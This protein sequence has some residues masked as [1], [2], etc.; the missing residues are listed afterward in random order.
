ML[1]LF[2]KRCLVLLAAGCMTVLAPS[3]GRAQKSEEVQ[4]GTADK[5]EPG[6][7]YSA[8]RAKAACVIL[9]H[10]YGGNR[11]Q[12]GWDQLATELQK[13]YA[14]L[15]FDF[16][17]HGDSTNVNPDFWHC[18]NNQLI[19]GSGRQPAKISYKDFLPQYLPALANDVAAAKRYLDEQNDAGVCNSSNVIVIGAEEGAAIGALWIASEWQRLRLTKDPFGR[20]VADRQ[21]TMEGDDIASA[22]WLSMPKNLAGSYVGYWLKGKVR[23][24]VPMVFFYGEQDFKAHNTAQ[25]MVDE[26]KRG[27][28]EKLSSREPAASPTQSWPATSC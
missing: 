11:Q 23:D 6:T 17:G 2:R 19:K 15:S 20:F 4:F 10:K 8:G 14:V 5:V 25:T 21:R 27:G 1:P 7:F 18:P 3:M 9:L 26:L 24:R 12:N 13:D 22:V 16:R 28:R